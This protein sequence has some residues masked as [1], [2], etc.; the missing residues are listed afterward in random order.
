VHCIESHAHPSGCFA[1]MGPG[2]DS[3]TAAPQAERWSEE[4][5]VA[6]AKRMSLSRTG[7]SGKAAFL[8]QKY[9]ESDRCVCVRAR[10]SVLGL[11]WGVGHVP[12]HVGGPN[13]G[14]NGTPVRLDMP[15][16]PVRRGPQDR[17]GAVGCLGA[18]LFFRVAG[19]PGLLS[20]DHENKKLFIFYAARK[21]ILFLILFFFETM[22]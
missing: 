16:T 14:I 5:S 10:A 13:R 6:V 11:G 1:G 7:T 15:A 21:K 19:I 17:L 2:S 18:R 8:T 3:A 22:A 20:R 4:E 9:W 12:L